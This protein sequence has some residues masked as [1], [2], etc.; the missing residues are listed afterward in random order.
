L[1]LLSNIQAQKN[2]FTGAAQQI[3]DY[4]ILVPNASNAGELEAKAKEYDGLSVSKKQ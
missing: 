1:L 2:D 3:R 4:L